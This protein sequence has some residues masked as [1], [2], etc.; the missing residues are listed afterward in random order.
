MTTG[1]TVLRYHGTVTG[2]VQGVGYR[3]FTR[4]AARRRGLVGW[5]RNA[6]NGG[7]EFEVAGEPHAVE[8]F[9]AHLRKGPP[10]SRVLDITVSVLPGAGGASGFVIRR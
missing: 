10:L 9:V 6:V 1:T 2:R 4:D 8:A 5:V 7:V 3:F